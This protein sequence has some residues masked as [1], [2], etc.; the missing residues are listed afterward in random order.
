MSFLISALSIFI[1]P[2]VIALI[3]YLVVKA[4][5]RKKTTTTEKTTTTV[6]TAIIGFI[7]V[8]AFVSGLLS[9]FLL[10]NKVFNVQSDS[11][12][13][14]IR[15]ATAVVLLVIGSAVKN[16]LQKYFLLVLG[17]F[18]LVSQAPYVFENFGSYGALVIVG[19][20]F[21]ALIVATIV[22]T[23]RH[24]NEQSS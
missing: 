1:Y 14:G 5:Q 10:P 9:L 15:V 20:A 6:R 12:A 17:L 2:A 4:S 19:I 8:S 23:K 21:I 18:M 16:K 22:L 13:F 7:M 24:N 3:I 11:I